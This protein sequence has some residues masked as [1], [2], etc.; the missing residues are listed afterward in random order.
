MFAV[1]LDDYSN[2]VG[3]QHQE[4][5]P[6]SHQCLRPRSF[7]VL[8]SQWSQTSGSMPAAQAR[9]FRTVEECVEKECPG[10]ELW[11]GRQAT[12]GRASS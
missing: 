11:A 6:E 7:T 1:N 12:A 2:A 3:Q 5:H 9:R 10:G 4:V 8:G